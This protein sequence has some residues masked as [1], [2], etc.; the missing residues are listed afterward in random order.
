MD[1]LPYQLIRWVENDDEDFDVNKL[2]LTSD[3]KIVQD[4]KGQY[5]LLFASNWNIGWA[6]EKNPEL[7]LADFSKN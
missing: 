6:E 2:S 7:R 1:M 4:F 3:T 5:L